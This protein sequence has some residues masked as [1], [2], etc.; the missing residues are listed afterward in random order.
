MLPDGQDRVEVALMGT[1]NCN[2]RLAYCVGGIRIGDAY[3]IM[4]HGTLR[5]C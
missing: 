5:S 1:A 2:A 4:Q 3:M